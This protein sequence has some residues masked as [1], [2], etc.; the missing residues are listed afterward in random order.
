MERN[1]MGEDIY[2]G[3]NRIRASI[4]TEKLIKRKESFRLYMP[5]ASFEISPFSYTRAYLEEASV[6]N[7]YSLLSHFI[8]KRKAVSAFL[9]SK[10]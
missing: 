7:E 10:I 6:N 4:C 9:E 3:I 2:S 5:F 8:R 1:K